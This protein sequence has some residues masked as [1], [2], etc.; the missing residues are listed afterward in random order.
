LW[1]LPFDKPRAVRIYCTACRLILLRHSVMDDLGQHY[2]KIVGNKP[3][4]I[5]VGPCARFYQLINSDLENSPV[6]KVDWHSYV[7]FGLFWLDSRYRYSQSYLPTMARLQENHM[8]ITSFDGRVQRFH[9]IPLAGG[10]QMDIK[11]LRELEHDIRSSGP[12]RISKFQL[13]LLG[14]LVGFALAG[15]GEL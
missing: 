8:Q 5:W 13:I 11:R 2:M 4:W 10:F 7:Y 14:A 3:S 6:G 12:F 15:P 1:H 9:P